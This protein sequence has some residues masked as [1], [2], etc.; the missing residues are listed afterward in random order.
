MPSWLTKQNLKLAA[1]AAGCTAVL[2][3]PASLIT[4]GL[5]AALGYMGRDCLDRLLEEAEEKGVGVTDILLSKLAT[6][7]FDQGRA[8]E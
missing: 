6:F 4:L 8:V 3:S 7:N 2:L 5:G 1:G